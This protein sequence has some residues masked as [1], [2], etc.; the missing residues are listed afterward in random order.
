M[1][2]RADKSVIDEIVM[3]SH[4]PGPLRCDLMINEIAVDTH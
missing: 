2:A 3:D 1:H 4:K